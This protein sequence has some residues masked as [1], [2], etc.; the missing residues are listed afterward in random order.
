LPESP[1]KFTP[2]NGMNRMSARA[3]T[4]NS[5]IAMSA[6]TMTLVE[7]MCVSSSSQE[8]TFPAVFRG[9]EGGN[10]DHNTQ[11]NSEANNHGA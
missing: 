6:G 2:K 8:A 5:V 7:N 10:N 11:S 4:G 3:G 9:C 1:P